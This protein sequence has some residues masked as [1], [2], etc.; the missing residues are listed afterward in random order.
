MKVAIIGG[1]GQLGSD[2]C[3]EFLKSGHEVRGFTHAELE[4][5]DRSSVALVLHE[6]RPDLVINTAAMHNV[7][8]CEDDPQSAFVSNALG[9]RNVAQV[10]SVLECKLIHIS[11]DYVFDGMSTRPYVET[12]LPAPQSVYGNSKLSGEHFV[13]AIAPRHFVVRVSAIYGSA[14]C[15]GKG[16]KNF[17]ARML[18]LASQ[19]TEIKVVAD[20][21]ITPTPTRQVAAQL[22]ALGETDK[23]GLYHATCEGSCSW[24]DFAQAIFEATELHPNLVQAAP[25][26]FP[27]KVARPKYSVLE[28]AALKDLH[29]N[30]FTDWRVALEG[31]LAECGP[32]RVAIAV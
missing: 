5:T 19:K 12:D 16:G 28:N 1:N 22:A 23:Y 2:V 24:Y 4:I 25:G 32:T 11:T 21:F 14:P 30:L 9:A 10:A 7:E 3:A 26:E 27:S 18:A 29:L 8:K 31:F 6:L 15:R 20:E 17:I 13:R